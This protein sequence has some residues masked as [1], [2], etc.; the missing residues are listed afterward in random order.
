M[1]DDIL[2][3]EDVSSQVDSNKVT[4]EVESN[5]IDVISKVSRGGNKGNVWSTLAERPKTRS[6]P[7]HG[8]L[9]S[10]VRSRAR[11]F[12]FEIYSGVN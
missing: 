2:E 4:P 5:S 3:K 10:K 7:A 11:S 9:I 12:L 1:E 8:E 6:N